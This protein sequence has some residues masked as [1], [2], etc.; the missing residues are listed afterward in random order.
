MA[1]HEPVTTTTYRADVVGSLL[2]PPTL[3]EGRE[4]LER[5]EMSPAKF[6]RLEDRAVDDAIALQESAG[7]DVI[8]DGELRRFAFY[9]HFVDALEGFDAQG[10]WGVKF[11]DDSG[12][13]LLLRRPVVVEKLR[14]KRSMCSEEW[15]Y[16]RSRAGRPGKVTIISA[17]Q[18]AS[19]YE[20]QRS[21]GAYATREAYL[22]DVV[23]LLRQE[24]DELVRLGCTYI[25]I[26]G[27]AYGSL[28][29]EHMRQGY[30]DRG[31]D[32]DRLLDEAIEM[33]NAVIAGYPDITFALHIC[34]GNN[35]SHYYASG[36]YEPIARVLERTNFGRFMLEYDTE[37]SGGFEPLQHLPDDRVAVL[38]LITT[39]TPDLESP[40]DVKARLHEASRYVPLDRLALSTQCG[41]ASTME[42][43]RVTPDDQRRKLELVAAVARDVWGRG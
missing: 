20:P 43:N 40:D 5:G 16:L 7:L 29:D 23:A 25:Q 9:G 2:R 11:R 42:G 14:W 12:D 22:A 31:A 27:P 32:P 38:G 13:E 34:R 37:R 1:V 26:D 36:G 30:R 41:F 33:D 6:K 24:V 3:K 10:G 35:Q 8:T 4:E 21:S 18:A 17:M 15:T 19:Y 28:V 39:K